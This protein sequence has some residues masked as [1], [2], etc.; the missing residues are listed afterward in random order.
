M[1]CD[2]HIHSTNSDGSMNVQDI[3]YYA[4]KCGLKYIAVSDHDTMHG[5]QAA[6]EVGK[7]IG[8]EVVPALE[9]T[10]IDKKRNRSVHILGYYPKYPDILESFLA[11]TLLNR[12]EQKLEMIKKIQEYYP[13][14]E[15]KHVERYAKMSQSIYESHIMQTMCDLGYTN[16]AIG[17]LMDE[18]ISK[19]GSCYVPSKYPSVD[20]VIHI[21]DQARA[22]I[23]IA[24]PEQFDSFELAEE[25]AKSNKIHGLELDHPRNHQ[26]S[27][28]RIKKLSKQYHLI[29]T[30][31]SDFH[32]QYSKNPNIIGSFG[33]SRKVIQQM[34]DI[35]RM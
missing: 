5:V 10:A 26:I 29:L 30:G 12:K 9:T 31:G 24:H 20:E 32:G 19:K 2:L 1:D 21:M 25:L 33:C 34:K 15:L 22:I 27:R 4:K 28:E 7:K 3:V 18:L 16:T 13:L 35:T 11:K 17:S 23:V 14:V 6:I 8:I